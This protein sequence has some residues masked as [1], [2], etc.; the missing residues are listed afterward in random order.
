MDDIREIRAI[1]RTEC[2]ARI[3]EGLKESRVTRI[4][5]SRVHAVGAG[6]DPEDFQ[7]TGEEGEAFTEKSRVEFV[8]RAER[9]EEL[10]DVIR[11]CGR[12]GHRGDGL[13]TVYGVADVF[14]IRTGDH[15]R[16][17]LQ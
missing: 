16:V 5:V 1:V 9:V 14:N 7:V 17:A 15:D 11:S 3:L 12:T 13:V 4:Y 8:C 6:V 2:L 10:L